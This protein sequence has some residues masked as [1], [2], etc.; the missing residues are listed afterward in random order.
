[1][2]SNQD[3]VDAL[4]NVKTTKAFR[5]VI[6]NFLDSHK[7]DTSTNEY[8][9]KTKKIISLVNENIKLATGHPNFNVDDYMIDKKSLNDSL[10]LMQS[11]N[12]DIN[13][14][15]YSKKN[16]EKLNNIYHRHSGINNLL[17]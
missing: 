3:N 6:N 2:L 5:D 4:S 1:M 10:F 8:I 17:T 13:H 12:G 14:N 15:I 16:L 7:T 11:F 9:D